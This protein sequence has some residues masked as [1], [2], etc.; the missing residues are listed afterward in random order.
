MAANRNDV[1]RL[2][3]LVHGVGPV[4]GKPGGRASAPS[5]WSQIVAMTTTSTVW[6]S[7]AAASSR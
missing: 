6:N 3:L 1:T 4:A 2:L 5:R 7:V